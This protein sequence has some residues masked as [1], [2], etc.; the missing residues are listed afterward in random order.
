MLETIEDNCFT[1]LDRGSTTH[2]PN[3]LSN[4][5]ASGIRQPFKP[6]GVVI[7]QDVLVE[8]HEV[9]EGVVH[10]FEVVAVVDALV[11]EFV[12]GAD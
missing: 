1:L 11:A 9:Q 12:G 4:Q 6:T 8:A 10:V 5:P 3:N 2:L 7:R